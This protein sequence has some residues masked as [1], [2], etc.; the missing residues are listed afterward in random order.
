MGQTSEASKGPSSACQRTAVLCSNPKGAWRQIQQKFARRGRGR[1][2]GTKATRQ[3]RGGSRISRAT[4]HLAHVSVKKTWANM[5]IASA[6]FCLR[7]VCGGSTKNDMAK[8][9]RPHS[10]FRQRRKFGMMRRG[11][12]VPATTQQPCH[13]GWQMARLPPLQE[14]VHSRAEPP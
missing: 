10:T 2:R 3:R 7:F 4:A 8:R 14:A 1:Q 12:H 11:K 5:W 6:A 13:H 9:K